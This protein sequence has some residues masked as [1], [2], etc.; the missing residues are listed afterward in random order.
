MTPST[1]ERGREAPEREDLSDAERVEAAREDVL[2]AVGALMGALQGFAEA[3]ATAE[4]GPCPHPDEMVER[5]ADGVFLVR[6]CTACDTV[7]EDE[8]AGPRR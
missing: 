8:G 7:L 5:E 1:A 2:R 4:E 6:R 3:I